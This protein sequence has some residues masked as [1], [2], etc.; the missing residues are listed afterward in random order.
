MRKT[1]LAVFGAFFAVSAL[2]NAQPAPQN[3]NN[4]GEM[5]QS[6]VETKKEGGEVKN[7]AVEPKKGNEEIK[8]PT[9]EIKKESGEIK[10]SAVESIKEV[11]EKKGTIKAKLKTLTGIIKSIDTEKKIIIVDSIK[12][13][14]ESM[15]FSYEGLKV[16]DGKNYIDASQ[17]KSGDRIK[18]EYEGEITSP[19]IKNIM[20][21]KEKVVE[22]K[23]TE[24]K[25]E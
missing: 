20:L 25:Q 4:S 24:K 16:K 18:M 22:K 19:T 8:N 14:G 3:T 12:K 10:K 13:K 15:T 6:A 1:I 23:N 9:V 21:I 7:P 5:K 17:L 2:I 11:K